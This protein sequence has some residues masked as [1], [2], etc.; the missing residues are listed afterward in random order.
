MINSLNQNRLSNSRIVLQEAKPTV[1]ARPI[2]TIG[3]RQTETRQTR[4]ESESVGS[5]LDKFADYVKIKDRNQNRE[6]MLEY[7]IGHFSSML[8]NVKFDAKTMFIVNNDELP[9]R[10]RVPENPWAGWISVLVPPS[11]HQLAES[12]AFLYLQTILCETKKSRHQPVFASGLQLLH[13]PQVTF[14]VRR[15]GNIVMTLIEKAL[16]YA[17]NLRRGMFSS[18]L[19]LLEPNV[20]DARFLFPGLD[21]LNFNTP[22]KKHANYDFNS[23]ELYIADVL[24]KIDEIPAPAKL[25]TIHDVVGSALLAFADVMGVGIIIH[26]EGLHVYNPLSIYPDDAGT[27]RWFV[28]QQGDDQIT[29]LVPLESESII[30]MASTLMANG[31][32][33]QDAFVD[34]FVPSL[35]R[36]Q[37]LIH[38]PRAIAS[39]K[40]RIAE[41]GADPKDPRPFGRPKNIQI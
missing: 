18:V 6:V 19:A 39:T 31:D 1:P 3:V 7:L 4:P 22:G 29:P 15:F 12:L 27:K 9:P 10:I 5:I 13:S 38:D 23:A 32:V 40:Y 2:R 26:K 33:D 25:P 35:Q 34:A 16:M 41:T 24:A 37:C 14:L 8:P 36:M 11:S 30:L 21:P 28:L 17:P 20:L